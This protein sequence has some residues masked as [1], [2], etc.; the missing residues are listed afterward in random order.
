LYAI[1]FVMFEKFVNNDDNHDNY[2]DDDEEE[3]VLCEAKAKVTEA[4]ARISNLHAIT[5][6]NC[7]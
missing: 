6:P 5:K 2:G 7:A 3:E 1:I 4:V